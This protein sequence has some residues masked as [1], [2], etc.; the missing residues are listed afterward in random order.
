MRYAEQHRVSVMAAAHGLSAWGVLRVLLDALM[1]SR[2]IL[3]M[4]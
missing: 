4:P 1:A 3:I 2:H